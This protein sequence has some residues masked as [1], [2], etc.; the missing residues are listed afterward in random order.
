MISRPALAFF[1]A[2]ALSGCGE[3]SASPYLEFAGGGF[4]FNYRNSEAF[5]GFVAKP[6]RTLPEGALIEASFDMPGGAQPFVTSEKVVPGRLQY[7]FKTPLFLR[8]V[9]KGR[10]YKAVMRLIDGTTGKELARYEKGFH[11]DV[12]QAAL[13]PK[14]L[15]VGPGYQTNPELQP[16]PN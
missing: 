7:S 16:S 12:D 11:T 8:G 6:L 10:E 1:A 3:D 5:Y 2:L 4:I 14:P 15:V 13:P 9:E